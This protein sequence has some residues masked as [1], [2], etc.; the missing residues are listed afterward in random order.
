MLMIAG[1]RG[2]IVNDDT[3]LQ[4]LF[5]FSRFPQ[6]SRYWKPYVN[7]V[8]LEGNLSSIKPE[9]RSVWSNILR[10]FLLSEK[11]KLHELLGGCDVVFDCKHER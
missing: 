6:G 11:E 5:R 3:T 4:M 8:F 9:Q 7:D 2:S 1:F 10:G